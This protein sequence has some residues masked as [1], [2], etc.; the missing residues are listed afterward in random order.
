VEVFTVRTVLPGEGRE[1]MKKL[2]ILVLYAGFSIIP[3]MNPVHAAQ[4]KIAE[5]EGTACMG[6]DRSRK[7]TEDHALT[8]AKRNAVEFVSTYV[9]S[10]TEVKN[11]VLEKD[12][13]TAYAQAEVKIIQMLSKEW[14]KDP[15]S[16]DCLKLKI[17]AE[18][19]PGK[20]HMQKIMAQN[21]AMVDDPS[22]PLTVKAW[23]DR[24]E[25]KKGEKVKIY[26]KGNKPFYA[27]LVYKDALGDMVQ[28][29]P[30]P[31]R[32]EKYFHGGVIYEIPSGSDRFDLEVS[33]PFGEESIILY[34]SSGPL[35]EISTTAQGGVFQV[36]TRPEDVGMKTRGIKIGA[37]EEG[38]SPAPKAAQFYE[39]IVRVT[40]RK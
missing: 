34:A 3:F 11:F 23:A 36:K 14:Y 6:D 37:R 27:R 17:K 2:W 13:L 16:G 18:V 21:Q 9:R 20:E 39:D 30:N 12:L 32:S 5:A 15:N 33:P 38:S 29:L 31:Y 24:K 8:D 19:I 4:S 10:E 28:I 40:T 26:I 22:A 25:Y 7:Q 1:P 35:G